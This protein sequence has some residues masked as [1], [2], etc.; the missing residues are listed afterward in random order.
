M[1]KYIPKR[2]LEIEEYTPVNEAY[3]IRL[4]TNE[5]PLPPSLEA[6]ES[7]TAALRTV[8]LNRYPDPLARKLNK[9]F[10]EA[11]NTSEEYITA[12][13]GSDELISV[14]LNMFL[15]PEDTIAVTAPDF[16]MYAFYAGLIGCNIIKTGKDCCGEIDFDLLSETVN[17]NNCKVVVFSN[18]CNPT[19]LAYD[20]ETIIK[21]YR[22]VD[23]IV[24]VDEAY[25]EFCRDGCSV[26]DLCGK[27]ER[28]I[29][30]KTLSKAY[31]AAGLRIGFSVSHPDVASA[32]RRVK[33]PYNLNMFSQAAGEILLSD[34]ETVFCGAKIIAERTQ[35]LRNILERE[36]GRSEKY[37][38]YKSDTNFILLSFACEKC[39]D[40]IY[41]GLKKKSI[42][43]RRPNNTHLRITCGT[44][45]ENEIFIREFIRLLGE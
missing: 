33:S 35:R 43:I 24:I 25:M 15:R 42:I 8:P 16:S 34:Y 29:V 32:V 28:L 1:N 6:I 4:D 27:E 37:K 3:E 11:Y 31:S 23:C 10:A 44:E 36:A 19:G 41:E 18:P 17:K 20:R 39:A 38:V 26:L 14:I 2:I 40:N 7:L 30:L 13:N 22:S 12:G 5:N 21:F 45:E 9:A